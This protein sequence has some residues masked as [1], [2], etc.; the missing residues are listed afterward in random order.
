[1]VRLILVVI[2][3][4]ILSSCS[5]PSKTADSVAELRI[6]CTLANDSSL[7]CKQKKINTLQY[8]DVKMQQKFTNKTIEA[9]GHSTLSVYK[10]YPVPQQKLLAIRGAKL[11]AFRN[12]A[13][14]IHGVRIKSNTTVKDM[15]IENDSYRAYVHA[16][17]RG[18]HLVT[19]TPKAG[20]IYEAEVAI[21]I[22]SQTSQCLYYP[23]DSCLH[24]SPQYNYTP[25][26]NS[27]TPMYSGF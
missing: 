14:E 27:I 13:E 17:L 10:N 2:F 15:V 21:T 3:G 6:N 1:M 25:L 5:S 23:T 12:L 26:S 22:V 16:M 24:I 8:V 7:L 9:V 4:F 18:A 11:D 19:I 20:G